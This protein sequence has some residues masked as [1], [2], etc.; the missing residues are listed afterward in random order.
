M[1]SP[2]RTAMAVATA[3][4]LLAGAAPVADARLQLMAPPVDP[5]RVT[6]TP[7]TSIQ[8]ASD[9]VGLLRLPDNELFIAW[10]DHG[11]M[12]TASIAAAGA[13]TQGPSIVTGWETLTSPA[14]VL[15]PNA[16]AQAFFGGIR[17]TSPTDPNR[18]LNV[19][20]STD[21]TT[22][23]LQ[24]GSVSQ[25][26]NGTD[27]AYTSPISAVTAGRGSTVHPIEAWFGGAGV[28]VH[29]GLD[30][31]TPD[32]E[33]QHQI[34]GR[35]GVNPRL[36][37]IP[38][39][40]VAIAWVSIAPGAEG[41]FVQR[42][43]TATGQPLGRPARFPGL[44]VSGHLDPQLTRT[45]LVARPVFGG[46]LTAYRGNW[47]AGNSV[48]VWS[49]GSP[50]STP[51]LFGERGAPKAVS[52]VDAD[53]LG[54]LWLIYAAQRS[55]HLTLTAERSNATGANALFGADVVA[56]LPLRTAAVIDV[57]T[58]AQLDRIDVL[59]TA[60]VAGHLR[61]FATQIRPGLTLHS[62][63]S[64]RKGGRRRVSFTVTDTDQ[65][66]SGAKVSFLGHTLTT[67]RHG[68]ASLGTVASGTRT[69]RASIAGYVSTSE[70]VR[71]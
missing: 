58:S 50:V 41:V 10:P 67:D 40:G 39:G 45:P 64:A 33:Y 29:S 21:L 62:K 32:V 38:G 22:W 1:T 26:A 34:G 11:T 66:I 59:V 36:V 61:T 14:I 8:S 68:A 27:Y 25:G 44:T 37:A 6:W 5:V 2:T 49:V 47:P 55:G 7:V 19:A 16:T 15:G 24:P 46:L 54:R 23:S 28:M 56:N 13:V 9:L 63:A 42:V 57:E 17:S 3:A 30:P 48:R 4:V 71:I 43:D 35:G 53:A 60:L 65:P 51:F 20:T 31:S 52:A 12:R 18:D 69:A 70:R